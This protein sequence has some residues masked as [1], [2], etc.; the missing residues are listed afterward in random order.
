[1]HHERVVVTRNGSPAAVSMSPEDLDSLEE[2]LA[3]LGDS[4]ALRELA[5]AHRAHAEGDVVRGIAAVRALGPRP[6]MPRQS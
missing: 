1:M 6:R 2:T 3:I 5:G 4:D